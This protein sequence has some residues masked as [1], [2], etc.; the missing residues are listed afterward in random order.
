MP[1]SSI[2]YFSTSKINPMKSYESLRITERILLAIAVLLGSTVIFG[3][4]ANIPTLIQVLPTFV[5]MQF[6]T[7]FFLITSALGILFADKFRKEGSTFNPI[8]YIA[9]F[10][11]LITGLTLLQY[12]IDK[13]FGLDELF[14]QHYIFTN[15]SHAGRMSPQTAFCYITVNLGLFLYTLPHN[16]KKTNTIRFLSLSVYALAFFALS[17][18]IFNI[19]SAYALREK[20]T[21]MAVHTA[22]GFVLL[23]L[24]L[25]AKAIKLTNENYAF[26]H[27]I[28]H[29]ALI[30]IAIAVEVIT[31]QN[32]SVAPIYAPAII[33]A[34]YFQ[35][36]SNIF[37]VAV[38]SFLMICLDYYISLKTHTS[39]IQDTANL[40]LSLL[41]VSLISFLAYT[42]KNTIEKLEHQKKFNESIVNNTVEAIITINDFGIIQS[43]N[44]AAETMFGYTKP[45]I[46]GSNI[47]IIMPNKIK[48]EHDDYLTRYR[49]T[50][51]RN[52]IGTLRSLQAVHKTNGLF[53][54]EVSIS[55]IRVHNQVYFT[56]IVRDVTERKKA[57]AEIVRSHHELER[58]AYIAS[59][60]LQE[61][62]RKLMMFSDLLNANKHNEDKVGTYVDSIHNNASKMSRLI[63]DILDYSKIDNTTHYAKITDLNQIMQHISETLSMSINQT[64]AQVIYKVL[65]VIE[66]SEIL[67]LQLLQN[68]I[69]NAIK[70]CSPDRQ[71]IIELTI[72]GSSNEWTFCVHDN[73]IGIEPENL[74]LVFEPFKR[75]NRSSSPGSGLG[76]AICKKIVDQLGGQIWVESE[77][78]QGSK[79]FWTVPKT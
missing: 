23:S 48:S 17:G 4:I 29:I 13:D 8:Q 24:A 52:V 39:L 14:F 72:S 32:I 58:F 67:I 76:L 53:D 7:A 26:S 28:T 54:I 79:F 75:L 70:Y 38:V 12:Y 15:T 55:E 78:G 22:F 6:N 21:Q 50:K 33:F 42:I 61:P 43:I 30:S 11:I 56:G 73:G 18:Y 59:H 10:N 25:K 31:P 16:K 63:K 44:K 5:P 3:W 2:A 77:L 46:I 74:E 62:L 65:P 19:E 20:S 66:V 35:K 64:Q 40:L 45:E 49:K 41:S 51:Q 36:R 71:P 37:I 60:D 9:I 34:I 57:E 69:G 68:I 27:F 47:N 1:Y